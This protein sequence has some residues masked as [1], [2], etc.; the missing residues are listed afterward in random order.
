[1]QFRP[2]VDVTS[3]SSE[4]SFLTEVFFTDEE[5]SEDAAKAEEDSPINTTR[6]EV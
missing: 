4:I 2:A 1:M 3:A 5:K 6:H